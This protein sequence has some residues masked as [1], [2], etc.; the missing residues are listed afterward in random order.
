MPVCQTCLSVKAKLASDSSDLE[1]PGNIQAINVP[2][3]MP[4]LTDMFKNALLISVRR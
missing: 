1:L 4:A 2:R 3:F